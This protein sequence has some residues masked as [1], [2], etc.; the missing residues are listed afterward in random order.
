MLLRGTVS[1]APGYPVSEARRADGAW[2]VEPTP[3]TTNS[4][5]TWAIAPPT[6]ASTSPSDYQA[7]TN[8]VVRYVALGR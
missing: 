4:D 2:K 3:V 7:E 1:S 6:E 8:F 5:A